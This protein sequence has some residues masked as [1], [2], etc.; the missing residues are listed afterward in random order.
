VQG[1]WVRS[2]PREDAEIGSLGRMCTAISLVVFELTLG[3]GCER[4]AIA[5]RRHFYAKA[6]LNLAHSVLLRNPSV[7]RNLED[8]A[9]RH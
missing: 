7:N 5:L 8:L 3:I 1:V 9:E 4:I 2:G 6:K